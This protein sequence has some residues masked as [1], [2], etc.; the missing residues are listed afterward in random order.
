SR[1]NVSKSALARYYLRAIELYGK[2]DQPQLLINEDPSAVNLEHVLPLNPS[3]EWQIDP[4][5]AATFYKRIGN[6]VLLGAKDNVSLGNGPFASKKK[7]LKES[8][9]TTTQD[10][11]ACGKWDADEI[12]K[13]QIKLAELAPK[14]WPL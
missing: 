5:T 7:I 1:A 14:V 8:P 13:R 2:E 9:F 12:R 3:K 6:M 10:V 11:G 4:E